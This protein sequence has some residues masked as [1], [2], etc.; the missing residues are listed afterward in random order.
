MAGKPAPLGPEA[1][2][3]ALNTLLAEYPTAFVAAINADGVFVPM[4]ASVPL[5]GQQVLQARSVLD[6]V[7]S[8]DRQSVISTWERARATGASSA[9]V[10]LELDTGRPA[11]IHY[12]DARARHGVYVGVVVGGDAASLANLPQIQPP[13]PRMARVRKNEV[14]VFLEI[15]EATT[16]ILGWTAADMVGVRSLDFIHPE[17]HDRAIESWMQMLSE[18]GTVQPPTRLRHRRLNGGWTWFEVTNHNRLADPDG[19]Y[20]LAEM[21]DIS[22]EMA[23]HE[24]LYERERLVEAVL[25]ATEALVIVLD[26][27]GRVERLSDACERLSGYRAEEILGRPFWDVLF[28][29]AEVEVMRAEFDILQ[30]GAFPNSHESQWMTV[31][32]ELRLIHWENTCLTDEGGAVTHVIATGIDI[33]DARRSDEALDGLEVVGRLFAEQGPVP[34]ALDA[35]LSELET[36]MGYRFLS[37]YLVD[38]HGLRLGV[39]R[40]YRSL[41]ERLD[42]GKGVI[43]RVYRTGL[44]EFVRDVGSDPDYVPGEE[45]VVSEIAAPLL[46]DWGDARCPQHRGA[47]AW[48][49]DAGRPAPGADH[50]GPPRQCPDAQPDA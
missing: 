40:G 48:R 33:T 29:S 22:E 23:A 6:L 30:A 5:T 10:R 17:D 38:G 8:E 1:L 34:A 44:A 32:G 16:K 13:P 11:V 4:P 14:A 15:D 9:Q 41:P 25:G 21:I 37:L 49:P 36:R 24:A 18:P 3:T 46:G 28:P 50:R 45:R 27:E 26:A 19:G 47:A 12:V 31:A 35:V 43:G 2:D 7:V 39:Q 42:A 20:V